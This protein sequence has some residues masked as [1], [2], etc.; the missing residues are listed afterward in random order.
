MIFREAA[1]ISIVNFIATT[2]KLNEINAI[3]I[4]K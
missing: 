2:M 1:N 4:A 3:E